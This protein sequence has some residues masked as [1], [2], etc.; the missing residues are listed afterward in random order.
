M[1]LKLLSFLQ[2]I[3]FFISIY[4]HH[5]ACRSWWFFI[6]N[7]LQ[8]SLWPFWISSGQLHSSLVQKFNCL[9]Q[10]GLPQFIDSFHCQSK[11]WAHVSF[12]KLLMLRH[13]YNSII[14]SLKQPH[15]QLI[16][17]LFGQEYTLIIFDRALK[18]VLDKVVEQVK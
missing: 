18:L 17:L 16:M 11:L 6:C 4:S 1:A 2:G 10:K 8:E 9:G 14:W 12:R 3:I 7:L 5:L 15:E 13:E